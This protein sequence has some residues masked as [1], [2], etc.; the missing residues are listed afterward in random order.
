MNILKGA[1]RLSIIAA[2][3]GGGWN[4]YARYE[5][6]M[7]SYKSQL[8]LVNTLKCGARVGEAEL[9]VSANA[10]G[11]YDLSK[12]GCST[13][14]FIANDLELKQAANGA[15][16]HDIGKD[17]WPP[18]FYPADDAVQAG[19]VFALVNLLG[20]A[21]LASRSVVLWVV[22]GFKPGT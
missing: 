21:A 11:N 10:Y 1:F 8:R 16:D 18:M 20:L 12:V 19:I 17:I 7:E 3:V 9:R 2:I 22:A 13:E 6:H 14:R 15:M 4:A 5:K